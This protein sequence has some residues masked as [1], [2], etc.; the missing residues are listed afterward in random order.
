MRRDTFRPSLESLEDRCTP[1]A[2]P[3]AYVQ[4]L[5][6]PALEILPGAT[7]QVLGRVTVRTTGPLTRI[8]EMRWVP[9]AG[10]SLLS[11]NIEGLV[12]L[13][14]N[15]DRL[16]KNG[17]ETRVASA[18]P[19]PETGVVTF[20]LSAGVW[21][22]RGR[23]AVEMQ[24]TA[25]AQ[26]IP[27]GTTLGLQFAQVDFVDIRGHELAHTVQHRGVAP[28]LHTV[29]SDVVTIRQVPIPSFYAPA[30]GSTSNGSVPL[31]RTVG[32]PLLSFTAQANFPA[33]IAVN[34]AVSPIRFEGSHGILPNFTQY[35]LI[36]TTASGQEDRVY[37]HKEMDGNNH[38]GFLI[39]PPVNDTGVWTL[40]ADIHHYTATNQILQA[41][42]ILPDPAGYVFNRETETH[43]FGARIN[44]K[45][46]G[47]LH[48]WV[49][50]KF[51]RPYLIQ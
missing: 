33:S 6:V 44:G 34:F 4:N 5:K 12:E 38:V 3:I 9:A 13:W 32:V 42:F 49:N 17:Y 37:Y 47:H 43:L 29:K 20:D 45:G 25:D 41:A 21:T 14:A 30:P 35:R 22:G 27:V 11:P 1:S 16:K 39:A 46:A 18:M 40:V 2:P 23:S 28:V 7:D 26:E 19:D 8:D 48:L 31:F 24:I 15:L 10:S 51:S 36:H 50:E